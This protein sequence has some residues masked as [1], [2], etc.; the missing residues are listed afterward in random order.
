MEDTLLGRNDG[1]DSKH[2]WNVGQF[3]LCYMAQ[4]RRKQSSSFQVLHVNDV[5]EQEIE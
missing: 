3:M 5:P 2:L 4:P 1:G